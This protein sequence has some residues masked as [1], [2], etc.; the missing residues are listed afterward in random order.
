MRAHVQWRHVELTDVP[1]AFNTSSGDQ[2]GDSVALSADSTTLRWRHVW[3]A[4][5]R[6]ALRHS[7]R[8]LRYYS[9]LDL[10]V[11]GLSIAGRP[12]RESAVY[13]GRHVRRRAGYE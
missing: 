10:R 9:G 4:A 6:P 8:Q 13:V 2:F 12:W 11:S 1:K 7:G 3:R 5:R